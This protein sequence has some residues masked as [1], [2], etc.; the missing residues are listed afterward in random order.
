[1]LVYMTQWL[2][3]CSDAEKSRL[4]WVDITRRII[5]DG[6]NIGLISNYSSGFAKD[7]TV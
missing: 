2:F 1:M 3:I 4:G 5:S 7:K 6:S